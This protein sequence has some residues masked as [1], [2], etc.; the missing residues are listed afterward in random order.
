M[1]R[2]TKTEEITKSSTKSYSCKA[3]RHGQEEK[4]KRKE[5]AWW[6]KEK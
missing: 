1:P 3:K 4:E 5:K 6:K 2:R